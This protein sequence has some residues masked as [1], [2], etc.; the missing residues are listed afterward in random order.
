MTNVVPI[1]RR[2]DARQVSAEARRR[3]A[4]E[5]SVREVAAIGRNRRARLLRQRK[6]WLA[7][8]A[9]MAIL[10]LA[11]GATAALWWQLPPAMVVV[12]K[13]TSTLDRPAKIDNLPA[14]VQSL[15]ST[16]SAVTLSGTTAIA[17]SDID[18]KTVH[19]PEIKAL[20][21]EASNLV[22]AVSVPTLLPLP[23]PLPAQRLPA[24]AMPSGI[25]LART[26]IL[27]GRRNPANVAAAALPAVAQ[28][29]QGGILPTTRYEAPKPI[30]EAAKV[31]LVKP[32]PSLE[33][34]STLPD[35]ARLSTPTPAYRVLGV[36]VD[37]LLQIQVGTDPTV[38][39][40]RVGERLPG[41]EVLRSANSETNFVETSTR[42][43]QVR[44]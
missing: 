15:S 1:D 36:P 19:L 34:I 20:P 7:I 29:N 40:V 39:Q 28:T 44:P 11:G 24:A 10:G 21:A 27:V 32:V 26:P 23:S 37:G 4:A 22:S 35:A 9:G 12:V 13:A 30:A 5:R 43:F 25:P 16:T 2:V 18:T 33:Q 3:Y 14:Q 6:T 17:Q 41:G 31:P 42:G 38:K 8:S